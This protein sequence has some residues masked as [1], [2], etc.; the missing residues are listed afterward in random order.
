M[1][2]Y[3]PKKKKKLTDA[4]LFFLS[5]VNYSFRTSATTGFQGLELANFNFALHS[6]LINQDKNTFHFR[7]IEISNCFK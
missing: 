5:H 2:L 4:M 1:T 6:K 7:P 3:L